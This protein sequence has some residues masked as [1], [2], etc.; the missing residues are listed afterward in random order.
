MK[1]NVFCFLFLILIIWFGYNLYDC[2]SFKR[3]SLQDHY[4]QA[5]REMK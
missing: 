5:L 2:L 4:I 1:T 3:V